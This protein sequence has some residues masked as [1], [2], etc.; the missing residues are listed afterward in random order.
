MLMLPKPKATRAG[1]LTVLLRT[2]V[3]TIP[4][5]LLVLGSGFEPESPRLFAVGIS[6]LAALFYVLIWR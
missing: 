1:P 4:F 6:G 3:I 2:A 5:T